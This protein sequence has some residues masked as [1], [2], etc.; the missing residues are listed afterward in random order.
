LATATWVDGTVLR[1]A[2]VLAVVGA[3]A[4]VTWTLTGVRP[5][6]RASIFTVLGLVGMVAILTAATLDAYVL[7]AIAFGSYGRVSCSQR[8]GDDD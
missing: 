3:G 2:A 6:L 5:R 4:I 8:C 1:L 7:A